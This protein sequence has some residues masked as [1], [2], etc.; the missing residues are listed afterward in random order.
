MDGKT[1][2]GSC[3]HDPDGNGQPREEAPRQQLS[4][5]AIDSRTVIGQIG[6][7]GR[8]DAAEGVALRRMLPPLAPGT[9]VIADALH[10]S[11][12][13]GVLIVRLGLFYI[14]QVKGNQPL[15]CEQLGEYKG[16]GREVRT[17]DGEHGRIETRT[18]ERTDAID[19]DLPG[20]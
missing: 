16:W 13:T 1:L 7:S 8:K 6:C 15:L 12:E 2:R 20:A 9:I 17:I 5:V 4:A 19:R 14:L 10:T 3:N 11:R 18:L